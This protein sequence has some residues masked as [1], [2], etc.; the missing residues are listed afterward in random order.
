MLV[1]FVWVTSLL[2][3]VA[4]AALSEDCQGLVAPTDY[5]EQ[6]QQDF[7][8]N[9]PALSASLSPLHAPIPH[10]P[11]TGSIGI[12]FS[13]IP[14]LGCDRRAVLNYTKT[15][16]TNKSP[17]LP[18]PRVSFAFKPLSLGSNQLIPYGS[19][20]F[21]PPVPVNGTYNTI[22]SVELGAGMNVFNPQLQTGFRLHA[23]LQRTVG[24]IAG[25][26]E[27]EVDPE[28]DDMYMSSTSGADFMIG[29][30]MN[31]SVTPYLSVGLTEVQSF[32]WIG[33]NDASG[34]TVSNNLHPYFGPA[35]SLGVDALAAER[36]RLGGEFY[37][38]PGGYSQ[39]D[40]VDNSADVEQ[41]SRYG[42]IYTARFRLAYELG[43]D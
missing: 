6:V 20:G 24:N 42:S 19:F 29:Y 9:F 2:S 27:P 7:L 15:E 13:V 37:T 26:F 11:G 30:A 36:L 25:A 1:S 39:L 5:N 32:F 3:P 14:P 8:Q 41:A 34:A 33:D 40:G 21:V 28:F 16:D 17:I 10:K 12:D 38:A 18:R 43:R 35:I 23:T 4:N 31:K 22:A